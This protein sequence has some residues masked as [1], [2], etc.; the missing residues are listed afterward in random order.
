MDR[1]F[2]PE[3]IELI[4]KASLDPVDHESPRRGAF[5]RY[6]I[7]KNYSLLNS[8][9]REVCKPSLY[10]VVMIRSE[11]AA[12]EFL[13]VAARQGGAI[14]GVETMNIGCYCWSNT[15]PTALL[16][17]VPQLRSLTLY[18]AAF[19]AED[20]TNSHRLQ[21]LT[22]NICTVLPPS[23]ST[24]LHIRHLHIDSSTSSTSFTALRALLTPAVLPNLREVDLNDAHLYNLTALIPQLSALQLDSGPIVRYL[25]LATALRLLSLD[26]LQCILV[27]PSLTPLT[28]LPP[29][30]LLRYCHDC[31][32]LTEV[33]Q[34]FVAK[35]TRGLTRIFADC[36]Y[37]EEPSSDGKLNRLI[38]ALGSKGIVVEIGR[39]TF[40]EAIRRMDAILAAEKEAAEK[41][42]W[43]GLRR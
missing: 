24:H 2:P 1:Q 9:W 7:F 17:C 37:D 5:G 22:L 18:F 29:F 31:R 20:L 33:L 34:H 27:L 32:R 25:P 38:V 39:F 15:R 40:P 19:H 30:L 12:S 11:R 16:G 4:V 42:E 41:R 21:N 26:T 6:S 43:E 23:P 10:K 3:I 13:R 36:N 28:P 8:T 14:G 35:S